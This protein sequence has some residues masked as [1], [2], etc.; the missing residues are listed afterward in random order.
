MQVVF[1]SHIP[2]SSCH[3]VVEGAGLRSISPED[4]QQGIASATERAAAE[5]VAADWQ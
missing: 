2:Q 3:Y 4:V 5:Q 1:S